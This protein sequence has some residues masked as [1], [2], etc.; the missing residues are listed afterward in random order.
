MRWNCTALLLAAGTMLSGCASPGAR[1]T[2]AIDLAP[3]QRAAIEDGI[4]AR[5]K[6]PESARFGAIKAGRAPDG[7]TVCGQVN[8]KNSF[9]GYTGM[10]TFYGV[11]RGTTFTEVDLDE[12]GPKGSRWASNKCA[13]V[14]LGSWIY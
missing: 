3:A 5:L 14:G 4:K 6:D 2:E 7:V 1:V 11:L 9:G 8:A 12:S 13:Q 10:E